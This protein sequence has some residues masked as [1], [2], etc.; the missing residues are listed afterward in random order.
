MPRFKIYTV[1]DPTPG[2]RALQASA[3]TWHAVIAELRSTDRRLASELT[4]QLGDLDGQAVVLR[5]QEE[6]A[7]VVLQR[8]G[9]SA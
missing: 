1:P 9:V 5:L 7:K 4:R 2:T 3:E 6:R 8:A